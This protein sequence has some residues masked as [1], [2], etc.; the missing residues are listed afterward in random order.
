MSTNSLKAQK[1]KSDVIFADPPYDFTEAQFSKIATVV[2]E[3][4]LLHSNGVLIIEHSKQTK[5]NAHPNFSYEKRY[6]GNVFSFFE[7]TN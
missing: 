2:F 4:D 7:K 6:G 5:L 3:N 1:T